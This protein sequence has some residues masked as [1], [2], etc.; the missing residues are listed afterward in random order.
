MPDFVGAVDQG[1]TSTRFMIFDHGG[2]EIARHQLE[3]EQILPQ[4]RLGR[5]RRHRDLG[6]HPLGHRHRAQQGQPDRG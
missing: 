1:T 5:A 4:A 6:T 3:H 2:N